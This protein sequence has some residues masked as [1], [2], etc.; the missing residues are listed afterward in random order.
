MSLLFFVFLDLSAAGTVVVGLCY[1]NAAIW[2]SKV[3]FWVRIRY[4]FLYG[5]LIL[6]VEVKD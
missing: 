4:V 2:V 1:C 5:T 3:D 6:L